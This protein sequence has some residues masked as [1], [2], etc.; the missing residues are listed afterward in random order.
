MQPHHEQYLTDPA[1]IALASKSTVDA[2]S[3]LAT[4]HERYRTAVTATRT[5]IY[6]HHEAQEQRGIPQI[7]EDYLAARA[8]LTAATRARQGARSAFLAAILA[9]DSMGTKLAEAR[10]KATEQADKLR[11]KLA[12]YES[13]E[14]FLT[15]VADVLSL[16]AGRNRTSPQD[17]ADQRR[18]AF[19]S[20]TSG[21]RIGY[22]A[23]HGRNRARDSD[24]NANRGD[25]TIYGG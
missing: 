23:A 5:P 9:D 18:H 8:E 22:E 19:V 25:G 3:A 6:H 4:S 11:A 17:V 2:A 7:D 10:R 13:T 1:V 20:M 14:G 12:E 15:D 16:L 21:T 24:R